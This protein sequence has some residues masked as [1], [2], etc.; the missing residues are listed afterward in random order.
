[1]SKINPNPVITLAIP[2]YRDRTLLERALRSVFAQSNTGWELLIVDDAGPEGDLTPWIAA[3]YG[4]AF[5]G[6]NVRNAENLG[7]AGNWNRCLDLAHTPWVTLL[8]SDDELSPDYVDIMVRAIRESEGNHEIAGIFCQARIIGSAPSCMDDPSRPVF[9]FVDWYKTWLAPSGRGAVIWAGEPAAH[10]LIQGNFIMCPT[11][12][13]RKDALAGERFSSQWRMVL[14]LEFTIR[15]L[16]QG[17]SLV[18]LPERAYAYRRHPGNATNTYNDSFLRFDEEIRLFERLA[19]DFERKG[20]G[21][22]ARAA[23]KRHIIQLHLCYGILTDLVSGRIRTA[24]RKARY[25]KD[26]FL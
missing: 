15:L 1:M 25:F 12:C 19:V 3:T 6:R 20:W 8:H 11:V 16:L 21:R 2:F 13:Y 5:C 26:Q 10:K 7:M 4:S 24:L 22:A 17:R 14:D 23:R 18:G 9:S